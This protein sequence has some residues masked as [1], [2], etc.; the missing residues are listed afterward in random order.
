MFGNAI[1]RVTRVVSLLVLA[2]GLG[3]AI[4]GGI[5]LASRFMPRIDV[6]EIRTT[7]AHEAADMTTTP[8][9]AMPG[10]YHY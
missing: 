10:R 8:R 4:Q 9:R 3:V 5:A 7:P 6:V 2:A 1:H